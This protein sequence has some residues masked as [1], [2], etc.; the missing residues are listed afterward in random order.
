[1]IYC[2]MVY[3]YHYKD[4]CNAKNIW[5]QRLRDNLLKITVCSKKHKIHEYLLRGTKNK[6][7][8]IEGQSM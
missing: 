1:L 7:V 8:K 6:Y 2:I 3:I 4:S 5:N